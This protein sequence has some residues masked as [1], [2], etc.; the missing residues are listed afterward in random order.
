MSSLRLELASP[1][2]TPPTTSIYWVVPSLLLLED[3]HLSS[4]FVCVL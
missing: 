3:E 2:S 1:S 4:F